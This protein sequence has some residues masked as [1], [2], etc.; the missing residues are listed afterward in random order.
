[1]AN[2]VLV[3][4]HSIRKERV[5]A[6]VITPGMLVEVLAADTLGAHSTAG[7]A[8]QKAIAVEYEVIGRG[9]DT[10]YAIGDRVLYEVLTAGAEFYGHVAAGAAAIAHGA[11]VQ[12]DGAGGFVTRTG[13]N[14]VVGFALQ[15]VDNS[16]GGTATTVLIEAV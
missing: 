15:A 16:G 4:G 11:A 8:A 10:N 6:T 5:A 9:T 1:M 3:K 2:T 14:A 13:T 12:S 7:G